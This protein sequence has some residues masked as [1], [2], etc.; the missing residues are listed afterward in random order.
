MVRLNVYL[1]RSLLVTGGLADVMN[2]EG[3]GRFHPSVTFNLTLTDF[4]QKVISDIK[5]T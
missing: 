5:I 2:I 1:V 4:G 3:A